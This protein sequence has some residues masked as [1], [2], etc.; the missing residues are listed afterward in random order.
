MKKIIQPICSGVASLLTFIAL[1][2][3]WL[4]TTTS[5]SKDKSTVSGWKLLSEAE[6]IEGNVL[7]R[8]S[9]VLLIILSVLLIIN[10]VLILLQNSKVI[11]TNFNFYKLNVIL[12]TLFV[13]LSSL[14]LI[15][16]SIMAED[17]SYKQTLFNTTVEIKTNISFGAWFMF[18]GSYLT[19]LISC[20]SYK[21]I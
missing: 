15:A 19:C 2:L 21:N 9:A 14:M 16:C 17:L 18:I 12:L 11:K 10:I 8:L 13:V 3:N 1:S 7:Y 5:L 20:I 6:N 4:I